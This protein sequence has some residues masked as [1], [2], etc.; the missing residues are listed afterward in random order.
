L[1]TIKSADYRYT[2]AHPCLWRSLRAFDKRYRWTVVPGPCYRASYRIAVH[3]S[4]WAAFLRPWRR[5]RWCIGGPFNSGLHPKA[6]VPAQA[7]QRPL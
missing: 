4:V 7:I 3:R 6:D 5:R 1:A 2:I